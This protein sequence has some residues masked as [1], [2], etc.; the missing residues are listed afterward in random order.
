[1]NGSPARAQALSV[2]RWTWPLLLVVAVFVTVGRIG[3][4]PTDEGLIQAE[5]WSLL[6]GAVPHVDIVSPRPLGSAYLHVI[7]ILLPT[8]LVGTSRFL[9]LGE[10][11]ASTLLLACLA[12]RAGWPRWSVARCLLC[13]TAI[14]VN[15]HTFPVTA[16]HTIDG[17]F[18]VSSGFV[19]L[20]LGLARRKAL[21][22]DGGMVAL[23]A[24]VLVKQSFLPAI[25]IGLLWIALDARG[26]GA[27]PYRR[28]LRG[29]LASSVPGVLYLAVLG[30]GGGLGEA[31]L[32]LSAGSD[33]LGIALG[34][35]F[36]KSADTASVTLLVAGGA[37]VALTVL[38][39]TGRRTSVGVDGRQAVLDVALRIVVTGCVVGVIVGP[40]LELAGTW[41]IELLFLLLLVVVARWVAGHGL[42]GIALLTAAVAMMAM[43][44]WGYPVPDLVAGSI[45]LVILDRTWRDAPSVRVSSRAALVATNIAALAAFGLVAVVV[46]DERTHNAYRQRRG[47][48]PEVDLGTIDGDFDGITSN[49]GVAR[50]LRQIRD[51]VKHHPAARVAVLP[52]NA[53]VYPVFGLDNPFP[54]SWMYT[55]EVVGST[56]PFIDTARRLSSEG[57]YLVLFE[58]VPAQ[59]A[60]FVHIPRHV[61]EGKSFWFYGDPLG[62]Q[63]R[64]NLHGTPITCGSFVGVYSPPSVSNQGPA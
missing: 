58:T 52:D 20:A 53:I 30:V 23:G 29:L 7:D 55:R 61:R 33:D 59:S 54:S 31:R 62:E 4:S 60:A 64:D 46:R 39:R 12:F 49:A 63:I 3:F 45:A 37:L 24:A 22:V 40:R 18:L 41:G 6:H 26:S 36:D 35:A 10:I 43:L 57:D 13:A 14:L 50:Y 56:Q 5:S 27:V 15:I 8:P 48:E 25:V 42:D 28:L 21:L 16:W 17:V 19:L 2:L 9:A 51:C 11:A 32:Q 44:S 1:M 34:H 38:W 47:V